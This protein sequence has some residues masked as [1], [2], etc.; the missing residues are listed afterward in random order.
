V[1]AIAA[2]LEIQWGRLMQAFVFSAVTALLLMIGSA[3]ADP[4]KR[5][6]LVVGNDGYR[7]LS[8]LHNPALD[9]RTLLVC[10]GEGGA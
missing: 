2:L 6:A 4:P 1:E 3:Q 7:S 9:A 8:P 5:V 10:C